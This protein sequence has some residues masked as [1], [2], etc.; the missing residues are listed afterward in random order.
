MTA[1]HS[2]GQCSVPSRKHVREI[3]RTGEKLDRATIDVQRLKAEHAAA[4][5]RR[6]TMLPIVVVIVGVVVIVSDL[7]GVDVDV[8]LDVDGLLLSERHWP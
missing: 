5:V 2:I 4:I 1:A 3:D 8:D 6:S 7:V